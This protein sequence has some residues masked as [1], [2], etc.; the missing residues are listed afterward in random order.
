[1][2]RAP[3]PDESVWT[4]QARSVKNPSRGTGFD[5]LVAFKV[6]PMNGPKG[7]ESGLRLNAWIAPRMEAPV[8]VEAANASASRGLPDRMRTAICHRLIVSERRCACR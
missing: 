8:A 1:M 5:A 2:G 3:G 7:R 6:D 4:S